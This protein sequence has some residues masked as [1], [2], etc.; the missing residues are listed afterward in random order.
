MGT[1]PALEATGIKTAIT[2]KL[3]SLWGQHA[4]GGAV[5]LNGN[6]KKN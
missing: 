6:T 4:P 1:W 5:G 2:S 3:A